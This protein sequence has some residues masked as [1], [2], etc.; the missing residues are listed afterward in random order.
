[1]YV[2]LGFAVA[3]MVRP[4]ILIVDE[5]IAVGDEE[6]QRKCYDHL[7][8][9][10]KA[11]TT[12]LIVSHGLSQIINLCDEAVWLDSG[13]VVETG[14][15][16]TVVQ[17][18]LD[19]VNSKE[20]RRAANSGTESVKSTPSG[21]RVPVRRGSGEVRVERI[22]ILQDGVEVGFVEPGAAVTF[23][24]HYL[25]AADVPSAVFGLGFTHESGAL[26]SGP[27]SESTA[28]GWRVRQGT[29]H[30]DFDVRSLILQPGSYDVATAIVDGTHSYDYVERQVTLKVRA[31][32]PSEPGLVR[33]DGTWRLSASAV[34]AQVTAGGES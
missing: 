29:G 23:R 16:R 34:A 3:V 17:A 15:L 6:F 18:Y 13:Q 27:N 33:M 4:D 10:R 8:T 2:R 11:G 19:R 9:L 21:S 14:S 30:V 24:I 12:M 28:G 1:M 31:T 25:A 26:T 5:V 20:A 22:E 32:G 7:H